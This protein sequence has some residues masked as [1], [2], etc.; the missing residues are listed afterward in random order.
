MR[1]NSIV[2]EGVMLICL[3]AGVGC[4]SREDVPALPETIPFSGL[5][6]LDGKPMAGGT[7]MFTSATPNTPYVSGF[8]GKD[9]KYVMKT[10]IGRQEKDGVV[11]GKYKISISRFLMADG[12]PQDPSVPAAVP[13]VESLPAR[14]SNPSMT[15]LE[16]TVAAGL[17]TMDFELKS[18]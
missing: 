13:G 4:S 16:V 2:F 17:T 3:A 15:Q 6:K 12:T 8:V 7:I 14:Y 9:G 1:R 11:P 5:V 18:R 10:S